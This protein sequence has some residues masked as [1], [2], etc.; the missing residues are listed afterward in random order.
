MRQIRMLPCAVRQIQIMA[1]APILIM[2]PGTVLTSSRK[3][4][5]RFILAALGAC[6]FTAPAGAQTP[7]SVEITG[8]DKLLET[9]VRLFLSIEQQKDHPLITE[10]RLKRLHK[11]AIQEISAA[12]QPYGYYRPA[13]D[14]SLVKS[15]SGEW[16]ATYSIDPG[17]A[18][19]IAEFNFTI[20][21]EMAQDPEF[22]EL[23]RN[24]T[25]HCR[26]T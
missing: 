25:H 10:G 11:K 18:L 6:L 5:I 19:P 14:S 8:I 21:P 3:C 1:R 24:P 23:L 7:V 20:N 9:N 15:D 13:I 26:S 12:L 4:L 22:A 17:P 2:L 16:R